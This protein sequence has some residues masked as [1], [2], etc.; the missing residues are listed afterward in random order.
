MND[1]LSRQFAVI[2]GRG[3]AGHVERLART[4]PFD[5]ESAAWQFDGDAVIEQAA[6]DADGN[7]GAR[8]GAA[9]LRLANAAFVN[10]QADVAAVAD[11]HKAGIDGGG[12]E[13]VLL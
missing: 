2:D 12:K 4:L 6:H 7:C 8:A 11:L 13:R 3:G 10:A 9:G 1:A 5:G